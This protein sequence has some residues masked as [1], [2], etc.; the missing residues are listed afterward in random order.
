MT[1]ERPSDGGRFDA[2]V[3]SRKVDFWAQV[4]DASGCRISPAFGTQAELTGWLRRFSGDVEVFAFRR[5]F[6]GSAYN[7]VPL[8]ADV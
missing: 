2:P 7:D 4:R 5:E 6:K 3:A 8:T 1:Y